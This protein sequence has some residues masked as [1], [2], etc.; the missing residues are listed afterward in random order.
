[1]ITVETIKNEIPE[2]CQR[3]RIKYVEIFGSIA[4]NE[5]SEN[6]DIDLVVELE[7]P[8]EEQSS[9]RF[10]GFLHF[11]EDHFDKKVDLL[12]PRSIKNPYLKQSIEREKIRIYG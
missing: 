8:I 2:A 3:F 7:D 6:S 5:F 10:F 4:R 12:T 1:M 9:T 11:L